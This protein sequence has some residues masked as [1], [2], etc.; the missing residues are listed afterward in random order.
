MENLS[1][2]E[3]ALLV[4]V[5]AHKDQCDKGGQPYIFHPIRVAMAQE[6]MEGRV[7]GLLHDVIEDSDIGLDDLSDEFP[8]SIIDALECLTKRPGEDYFDYVDRVAENPIARGIKLADLNDNMNLERLPAIGQKDI[9]RHMKYRKAK[10]I[11]IGKQK[12]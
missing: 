6:S 12:G 11:L 3:R 2:F 10:N 4:A 9:E 5:A 8:A 7:A 1:Y